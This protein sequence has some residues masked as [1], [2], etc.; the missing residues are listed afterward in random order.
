MLGEA[1]T[2]L[3]AAGGSAVVR[4][5]GTDLWTGLRDRV[6]RWFSRGDAAREDRELERLDHSAAELAAAD[7]SEAMAVRTR[8]E[9]VWQTRI[10]AF[11]DDLDDERRAQAA[12]ELQALLEESVPGVS[13]SGQVTGNTFEGPT[14]FQV[15][16]HNRQDV[17]FG[18]QA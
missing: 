5:A 14:A 15:G 7:V 1:L 10:E 12:A 18:P 4:A 11:L 2:A 17:R 3:A 6:A 16:N 9:T 13:G 8:L